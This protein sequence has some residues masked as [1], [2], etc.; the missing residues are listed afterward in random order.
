MY[1]YAESC[2]GLH[3]EDDPA[4]FRVD[5]GTLLELDGKWEIALLDI[6]LPTMA[7]D[8]QP[9]YLTFYSNV[10]VES[11]EDGIQ[12][13]ILCRLFKSNFRSGKAWS[14]DS[15]RYV[16]L[17]VNYLRTI[18]I[19]ILDQRGDK[20]SFPQGRTTCTLHLRRA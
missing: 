5:L 9:M 3:E 20:P 12:R 1:V 17:N 6:D 11:I 2:K 4:D 13:P 8:Y 18:R 7:K 14:I 15:P 10:C 16:P 19:Y